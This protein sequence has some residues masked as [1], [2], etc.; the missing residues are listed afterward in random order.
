MM[1][2][3]P[4]SILKNTLSRVQGESPLESGEPVLPL[5]P[6]VI[7]P[8]TIVHRAASGETVTMQQ[9]TEAY[10]TLY[11]SCVMFVQS[12]VFGIGNRDEEIQNIMNTVHTMKLAR[13]YHDLN[14][15]LPPAEETQP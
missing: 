7:P 10:V 4:L 5:R 3:N 1:T 9:L 14:A 13:V 11:G 8:D 15:K 6:E 12:E 2:F